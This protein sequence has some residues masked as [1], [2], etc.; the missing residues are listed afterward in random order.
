MWIAELVMALVFAVGG[1][2]ACYHGNWLN[3]DIETVLNYALE[4]G[5]KNPGTIWIISGVIAIVIGVVLL[6]DGLIRSKKLRKSIPAEQAEKQRE[7]AEKS[8]LA[9]GGW[10][11]TCGRVNPGYTGTCACGV[12]KQDVDRT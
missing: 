3:N 12:R 11:C 8:M 2:Y 1:G 7:A 5:K 6:E 10:K 9:N 4:T